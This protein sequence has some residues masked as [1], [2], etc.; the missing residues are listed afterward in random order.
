MGKQAS[1]QHLSTKD[2]SIIINVILQEMRDI[3]VTLGPLGLFSHSLTK[4][5][6]CDCESASR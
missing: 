4:Y 5:A 3:T 6:K 2:L 1:L